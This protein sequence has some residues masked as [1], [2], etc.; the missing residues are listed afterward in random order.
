MAASIVEL[1]TPEVVHVGMGAIERVGEEA[2]RLG[3]K[4]ALIVTDPGIAKTETVAKVETLLQE[5]GV[6]TATFADVEPE[7]P[8]AV[9]DAAL[10][11]LREEGCDVL[12]GVGGGSSM[13]V[14]K[15]CSVLATNDGTPA[16]YFGVGLVPKPGLPK[17]LVPTTSGTGSEVTPIAV[18]S[19]VEAK[20]KK[21]IVSPML[22]G[23]VAIVDPGLTF[24]LPPHVTAATGMDALTHAVEAFVSL[25]A[26]PISDGLALEAMRLIAGNLVTAYDDGQNAAAREA[27]SIAS[28]MAGM[29]LPLAG[30]AAV[31]ALAY[32]LGGEFHLS[33]GESNT[34]MLP[35]VLE[36][37]VPACAEKMARMAVAL[38][39]D[40]TGLATEEAAQKAVDAMRG[41]AMRVDMPLSLSH[42]GIPEDAIPRMAEAA[43]KITRLMD[44]NPRPA[45]TEEI[46]GIYRAAF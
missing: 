33:H 42:Y 46:A 36:Y 14:T 5:A 13:D 19:D 35:F 38:G 43:A 9:V 15:V 22:Y 28:T 44:N 41:L 23:D 24:S 11:C 29:C 16:D 2:G 18:L 12:V 34:L 45:G 27:M 6:G 20:V 37:N 4:K 30:A 10:A 40:V 1:R 3:G 25:K 7:P 31:H 21:G 39:E 8:I 26:N 17:V 32:P